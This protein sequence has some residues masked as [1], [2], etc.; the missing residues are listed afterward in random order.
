MDDEYSSQPV[1]SVSVSL[2]VFDGQRARGI[3]GGF[4]SSLLHVLFITLFSVI[5]LCS[6]SEHF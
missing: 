6:Y 5:H 1:P 3:K 2:S 4:S